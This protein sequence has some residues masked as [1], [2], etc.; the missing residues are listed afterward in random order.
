MAGRRGALTPGTRG[1]HQRM[2]TRPGKQRLGAIVRATYALCLAGATLIHW[3][4]VYDHGLFWDYGGVPIA[5]AAF[6]TA[7]S[8]LD[9]AAVVLLFVRPRWGVVLTGAIIVTDVIHNL[10]ILMRSDPSA[11]VPRL[12]AQAA[13]MVF[14]LLTARLAFTSAGARSSRPCRGRSPPGRRWRG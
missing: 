14:V 1:S 13:F 11:L 8:F 5:S 12:F 3:R 2:V 9:P 4:I 6:W 7:L 10:W